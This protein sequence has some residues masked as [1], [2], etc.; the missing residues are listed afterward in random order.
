MWAAARLSFLR[1]VGQVYELRVEIGGMLL[2]G[3]VAAWFGATLLSRIPKQRVTGLIAALLLL[4][5]GLLALETF[6]SGVAWT[7]LQDGSAWRGPVAVIA[8]V[9]VGLI[10]SLLGVAGGEFIIPIL[11][12]I[13]GADIKTAGTA[14]VLISIPVVL[15]GVTRH[16]LTGH[17][18]SQSM[19]AYLVLPMSIGSLI[20]AAFGAYLAV[21][22]PTDALR[23]TLAI[24]LALS[25][26]K[27]W[28]KHEGAPP[29]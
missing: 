27:L 23:L 1:N 11:I 10:S 26:I 3:V 4:T 7:A 22:A 25:A 12:F 2:G 5:A 18:R 24:I 13:F 15:A 6:V 20:G 14:S 21:W 9:L 17:Y 28:S 29:T 19:L 16:W 8:G